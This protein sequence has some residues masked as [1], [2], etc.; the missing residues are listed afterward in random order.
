MIESNGPGIINTGWE[1]KDKITKNYG[2]DDLWTLLNILQKPAEQNEAE[3]D[4]DIWELDYWLKWKWNCPRHCKL[5]GILL[6]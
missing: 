6:K 4:K 3:Q 2:I 1:I 5:K